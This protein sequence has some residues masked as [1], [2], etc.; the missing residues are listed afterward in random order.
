MVLSW[1][2]LRKPDGSPGRIY[3]SFCEFDGEGKGIESV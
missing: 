2:C 3:T 1:A